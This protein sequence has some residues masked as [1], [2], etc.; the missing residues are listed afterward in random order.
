VLD[1]C[2]AVSTKCRAGDTD[3]LQAEGPQLRVHDAAQ[4]VRCATARCIAPFALQ[5]LFGDLR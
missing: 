2:A 5:A 3:R 4:P 1:H